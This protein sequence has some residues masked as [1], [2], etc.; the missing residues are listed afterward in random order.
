MINLPVMVKD[1]SSDDESLCNM[2]LV[3]SESSTDSFDDKLKALCDDNH[4]SDT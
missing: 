4:E 3:A 2:E 1:V